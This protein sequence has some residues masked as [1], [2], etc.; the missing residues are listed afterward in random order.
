MAYIMAYIIMESQY[1]LELSIGNMLCNLSFYAP[2]LTFLCSA[3]YL[4][5]LR[6]LHFCA[7]QLTFLFATNHIFDNKSSIIFIEIASLYFLSTIFSSELINWCHLVA[8]LVSNTLCV[9]K[10]DK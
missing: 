7:Q 1:Q 3:T 8:K 10:I 9:T 4:S 6:N 2:Q 5:M